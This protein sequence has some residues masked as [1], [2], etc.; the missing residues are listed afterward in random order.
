M[1]RQE[2][3]T[4]ISALKQTSGKLSGPRGAAELLGMKSSSLTSRISSLGINRRA[5]N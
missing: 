3:E 5:L 4:I 1:K 2:R